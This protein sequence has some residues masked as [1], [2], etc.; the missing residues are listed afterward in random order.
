MTPDE[1]KKRIQEIESLARNAE[2][3]CDEMVGTAEELL[4]ELQKPNSPEAVAAATRFAKII[5]ELVPARMDPFRV[6]ARE[7]LLKHD[8]H[9]AWA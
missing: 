6:D 7:W 8:H 9:G 1:L 4:E 3:A 2:D 5:L